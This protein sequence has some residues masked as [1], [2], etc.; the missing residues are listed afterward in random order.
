MTEP[1]EFVTESPEFVT[2]PPDFAERKE[3]GVPFGD[4]DWSEANVG[5][6]VANLRGFGSKSLGVRVSLDRTPMQKRKNLVGF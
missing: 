1:P 5:G 2:E 6:S 4:G 3:P